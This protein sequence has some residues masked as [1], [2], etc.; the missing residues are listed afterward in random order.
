[1]LLRRFNFCN[2]FHQSQTNGLIPKRMNKPPLRYA[3]NK[4]CSKSVFFIMLL[5]NCTDATQHKT[6]KDNR[7]RPVIQTLFSSVTMISTTSSNIC[8][9]DTTSLFVLI[10]G[11]AGN[12]RFVIGSW[13]LGD[14][15]SDLGDLKN[16][17]LLLSAILWVPALSEHSP[18]LS[19]H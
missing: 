6:E 18:L 4:G 17:G 5:S 3:A 11:E 9:C 13:N 1:M 16:F 8:P 10:L 19:N 2:A 14:L 15:I 12:I 7:I